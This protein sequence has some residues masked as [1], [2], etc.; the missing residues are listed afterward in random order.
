MTH[1]KWDNNGALTFTDGESISAADFNTTLQG[2]YCPIGS[3]IAWA[4]TLWGGTLPAAWVECN[5]QVLS[6]ATSPYNGQTVP[7]LNGSNYFLRG[8]STSGGTGGNATHTHEFDYDNH[9][10]GPGTL[11]ANADPDPMTTDATSLLPP[12]YNVVYIM[13]IK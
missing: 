13:R 5:G 9:T 7:D 2:V 1:G 3:V 6:D 10:A 11:Y 4:K 8:N 12:Y